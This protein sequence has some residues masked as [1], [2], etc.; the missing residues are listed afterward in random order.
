M[1]GSRPW[2]KGSTRAF[3]A[4]GVG[5]NPTG[6]SNNFMRFVDMNSMDH[7]LCDTDKTM[8]DSTLLPDF[9]V[10]PW[11]VARDL[12]LSEFVLATID[13]FGAPVET[14]LVGAF[15]DEGRGAQRDMELDMH[16]DGVRSSDLARRQGGT[17]V[18][19]PD[20]DVVGM[21]CVRGNPECVTLVEE[22][23]SGV[24]HRVI[25]AAGEAIL[26]DNHRVR[27]GREGPVGD[28]VLLRIWIKRR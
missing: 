12:S 20:V 21:Y 24:V 9:D 10:R 1:H 19:N 28:R 18:E 5:S 16:Q 11:Y 15:R 6:R 3:Q 8:S 2:C 23:D 27:H 4:P 13:S 7:A 26:F 25:L 22:I 17:Y 14:L